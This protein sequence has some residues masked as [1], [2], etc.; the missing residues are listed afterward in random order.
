VLLRAVPIAH[1]RRKPHAIRVRDVH[2]DPF[3]HPRDSHACEPAGI[4]KGTRSLGRDH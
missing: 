2:Y 1:D 4:L 3:A